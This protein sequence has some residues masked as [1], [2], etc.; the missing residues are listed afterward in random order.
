[1][2]VS[3]VSK[4]PM[5][6]AS[7]EKPR[8]SVR[9]EKSL[10][11]RHDISAYLFMAPFLILFGLFTLIPAVAAFVI[12]FLH[13]DII[14]TP[15]FVGLQNFVDIFRDPLFIQS[16]LNTFYFMVL[17][18]IPLIALGLGLAILVNQ[19]LYGRTIARALVY[20]PQVIMVSAVGIIWV[21]MY[22]QNWGLINYYLGLIGIPPIGWLNNVNAA[23]PALAITTIWWTV[24][25]NMIIYLAGL[26]DIPEDLYEAARIDGANRWVLFWHITWPQLKRVN[27]FVI[28]LTIISCWRVFGQAYVMTS[29]GPQGRTFVVTQYIYQTAF[30]QFQMGPA[31]AAAVV[32]LLI[33]LTF[34]IIQLRAMRVF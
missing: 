8:T 13:W 11:V 33:T 16:L 27:T 15:S 3:E 2:A 32:L 28:P 30:Q 14:G 22:D 10:M 25:S 5:D 18:A 29:G 9:R 19:K 1:M 7:P 24:G 31:S 4:T 20:M 6:K 34:T 23:L 17:S 12:S 26:Q 21:W